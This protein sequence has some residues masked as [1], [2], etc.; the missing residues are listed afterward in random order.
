MIASMI[1]IGGYAVIAAGAWRLA[2]AEFF[3]VSSGAVI[4]ASAGLF[5]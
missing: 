3:L 4:L 1:A 2:G 5:L